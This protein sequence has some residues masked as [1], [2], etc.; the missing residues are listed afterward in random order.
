MIVIPIPPPHYGKENDCLN[1]FCCSVDFETKLETITDQE[2]MKR[3]A[4]AND[5]DY[6]SSPW[7][8]S[9]QLQRNLQGTSGVIIIP[10]VYGL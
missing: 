9:K 10:Y 1:S 6:L 3:L 4:E 2:E 7:A 5:D 8:D